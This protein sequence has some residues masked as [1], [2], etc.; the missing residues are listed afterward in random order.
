M[1]TFFV[2]KR[3]LQGKTPFKTVPQYGGEHFMGR[4]WT[5]KGGTILGA[6]EGGFPFGGN[7]FLGDY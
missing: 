1:F 6:D 2:K 7:I 4:L 3:I 5:K